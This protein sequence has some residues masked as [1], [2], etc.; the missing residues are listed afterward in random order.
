MAL[1]PGLIAEELEKIPRFDATGKIISTKFVEKD[2]PCL[3][4]YESTLDT[5]SEQIVF[6]YNVLVRTC[7]TDGIFEIRVKRFLRN[8]EATLT[9][10]QSEPH[11]LVS[12]YVRSVPFFT[13]TTT[14]YVLSAAILLILVR[15]VLLAI[16][17]K[18]QTEENIEHNPR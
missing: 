11:Q 16:R 3:R 4:K 8:T 7:I 13:R 14:S 15:V 12:S 1:D 2:G 6:Y 10:T 18:R 9:L 5:G 17:K